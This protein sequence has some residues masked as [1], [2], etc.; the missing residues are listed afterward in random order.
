MRLAVGDAPTFGMPGAGYRSRMSR[1]A[2]VLR[3]VAAAIA[4]VVRAIAHA[5]ITLVTLPFRAIAK[6]IGKRRK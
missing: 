2:D 1:I 5:V 4:T 6:L 3:T